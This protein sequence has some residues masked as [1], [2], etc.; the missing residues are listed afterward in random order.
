MGDRIEVSRVEAGWLVMRSNMTLEE[1]LERI[2][3]RGDAIIEEGHSIK[4]LVA[5]VVSRLP[6]DVQDWLL[7]ET[8]HVFIAGSGQQGEFISLT[9]VSER[10]SGQR[11][12][13]G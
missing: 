2:S 4:R 9:L 1:A 13:P 7:E 3:F 10:R 8:D 5:E 12:R 6:S 11:K